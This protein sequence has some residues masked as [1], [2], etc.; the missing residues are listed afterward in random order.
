MKPCVFK[1]IFG[2]PGTGSHSYRIPILDLA[3][4]DVL[5]TM[6]IAFIITRIKKEYSFL[7]IFSLLILLSI[8]VHFIFC[9]DTRLIQYIKAMLNV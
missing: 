6:I 4:I 5:F 3:T 9:V 2:V 1:D 7:T 8:I